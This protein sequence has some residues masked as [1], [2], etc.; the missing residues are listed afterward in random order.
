MRFL[1][2]RSVIIIINY[3]RPLLILFIEKL[4]HNYLLN[5]AT[6]KGYETSLQC[7]QLRAACLCS[8]FLRGRCFLFFTFSL[9]KIEESRM[10][11]LRW[12]LTPRLFRIKHGRCYAS[13]KIRAPKKDMR[14]WV[15]VLGAVISGI[16]R[17]TSVS[18]DWL[19]VGSLSIDDGDYSENVSF[20]RNSCFFNLSRVYS[21]CWKWQV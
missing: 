10:A 15:Q 11:P 5:K 1:L 3:S 19:M 4:F 18:Y 12:G 14:E 16:V 20:K 7:K 13:E 9:T 6:L 17:W 2:K 21:I 8:W